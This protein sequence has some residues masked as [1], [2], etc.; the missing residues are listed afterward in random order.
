MDESP[1]SECPKCQQSALE[2][3]VSAAG[4]QLKG[5]GWYVTDFK[6]SKGAPISDEPSEAVE[7]SKVSEKQSSSESQD[8]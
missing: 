5:T 6:G 7:S 2:K 4:F 1:M 8:S 3:K